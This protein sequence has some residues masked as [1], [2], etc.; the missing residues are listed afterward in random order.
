MSFRRSWSSRLS[1]DFLSCFLFSTAGCR[2][3]F[4]S[5]D[6]AAFGSLLWQGLRCVQPDLFDTTCGRDVSIPFETC[7]VI[8]ARSDNRGGICFFPMVRF[9]QRPG[10]PPNH[11]GPCRFNPSL[12]FLTIVKRGAARS[13]N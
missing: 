12:L 8:W 9:S 1:L 10:R 3:L 6:L 7:R 5:R 11:T 2:F 4:P 13:G